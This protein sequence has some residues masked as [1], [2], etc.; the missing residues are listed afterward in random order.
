MVGRETVSHPMGYE[1]ARLRDTRPYFM[2]GHGRFGLLQER[3]VRAAGL[4]DLAVCTLWSCA[5]MPSTTR[6]VPVPC[7]AK[8]FDSQPSA[9]TGAPQR[10]VHSA[11]RSRELPFR[12]SLLRF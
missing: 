11:V 1:A 6:Q 3:G 8:F 7:R 9:T 5:R 2:H 12:S 4:I 10:S